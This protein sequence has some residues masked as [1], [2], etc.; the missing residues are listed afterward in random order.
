[1]LAIQ[2]NEVGDENKLIT[3]RHAPIPSITTTQCLIENHYAGLNFHDTYTRSGLY[4]LPLP[5]IVGC[6][7]GGIVKEVGNDVTVIKPGDNGISKRKFC[8]AEKTSFEVPRCCKG[9]KRLG[10]YC[11]MLDKDYSYIKN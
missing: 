3:N 6:E 2:V 10:R 11:S 5:F 7:G 4:P 9:G 1:M 8:S